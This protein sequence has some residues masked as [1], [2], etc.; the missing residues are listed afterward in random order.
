MRSRLLGTNKHFYAS[1]TLGGAEA[2]RWS[3]RET[4]GRHL[5]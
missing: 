3:A 4:L 5:V 2:A 1:F